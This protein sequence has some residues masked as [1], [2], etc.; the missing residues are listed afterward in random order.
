[1]PL[2]YILDWFFG[3]VQ[4]RVNNN[5]AVKT[6][7]V[8]HSGGINHQKM[9]KTSEGDLV[10]SIRLKDDRQVKALLDKSCIK[11][12]SIKGR[13]LPFL[14]KRYKKRYGIAVGFFLFVAILFVSKLFV[15]EV[16]IS[17]ND[18]VSSE[19]VEE[20]LCEAGF[21]VGTFIP[22]VDFYTLCNNFLRTT[23]DFSFVSVNMEG[24]TAIVEVRERKKAP[25][26][27]AKK[28]SNLVAKYSGQIESMTVY[29]GKTV[30]EKGAVV[31]EGDL[32]VSGFLEKK[33]GFDIVRSSGSI[34]AYVT[35]LI[36][37]DIPFCSEKKVYSGNEQKRVDFSFFGKTF[38]VSSGDKYEFGQYDTFVDRERLVLF[39]AVRLPLILNTTVQ[40]EYFYETV[41]IDEESAKIEADRQMAGLIQKE[42]ADAEI[43][44]IETSTETTEEGYKLTCK[45][46]CL[47][48]I[49]LEKEIDV[50]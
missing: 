32:L 33:I 11:V 3:T 27:E 37:V 19:S 10:F 14:I 6:A 41:Y 15:W 18:S 40:K 28:A 24:T 34:Y 5:D 13:G 50:D 46:Y 38:S 20:Q 26:D 2:N 39:D 48:D 12:Y 21:G 47:A 30:V 9:R 17:G 45:I 7:N 23:E 35:R 36:E 42:L 25:T 43:L 16:N 22:S 1:M 49:A 8:L 44:E 4:Y 31:K 29:S